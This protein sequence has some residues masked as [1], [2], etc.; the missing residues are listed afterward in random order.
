MPLV[1]PSSKQFWQRRNSRGRLP[2][3]LGLHETCACRRKNAST[4]ENPT[5]SPFFGTLLVCDFPLNFELHRGM[6]RIIASLS[7]FWLFCD[8]K[9]RDNRQWWHCLSSILPGTLFFPKSPT[10]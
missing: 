6:S 7:I 1:Y 9:R 3:R 5:P 8:L 10:A 4:G 2:Q